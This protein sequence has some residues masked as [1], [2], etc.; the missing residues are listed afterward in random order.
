MK[1]LLICQLYYP[2]NCVITTFAESLVKLGHEVEVLTGK[3]NYGYG[4]ILEGYE[5]IKE[6]VVTDVLIHRVNLIPRKKN[7]LSIILNY[8]S[9]W[10][11]SKRWARRTKKE[12]DIVYSLSI[13]PVTALCAGNVYKKKHHVPHVMHVVDIWPESTV[14][15]KAVKKDSLM[16]KVLYK[17]SKAIYS[18][19][20]KLLIG[21]PSYKDYF[22]NVLNIKNIP[23]EFLPQPSLIEGTNLEPYQY[24]EGFN[25]LYCGNLG[26]IQLIDLIPEAMAQVSNQNVYFHV[27]GMG[28]KTD[29][30]KRLIKAY[31]LEDKIIYHGP[32]ISKIA[33]SYY[34]N[35]D[36]IYISL[37]GEGVVGKTI[38]N[39]LMMAMAFSKPII[40]VLSGDGK[41]V[42]SSVD[43]GVSASEIPSDIASK[44]DE[45]ST[46]SKDRL[47]EIGINNREYY[48]SSFSQKTICSKLEKILSI[49][50]TKKVH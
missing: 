28:P 33:A 14:A 40:A 9:F 4:R 39:K 34:L 50:I 37:K 3:P 45:I 7:R 43:S 24:N 47:K 25:I 17:W 21:S 10:H 44:I 5:K 27:I 11:N 31:K 38:P 13:S 30:L 20:D 46:Y 42:L 12:F 35:A 41:K 6:E 1:I 18:K 48:L 2:E 22:L 36:A 19:A 23:I 32:I 8:L 16:Y 26:R 29:E 15:T 49:E